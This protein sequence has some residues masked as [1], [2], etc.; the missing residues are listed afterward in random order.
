MPKNDKRD[1]LFI[2]HANPEDNNFAL[3]LTLRLAAEG[4]AV[5]CDLTE[6]LGGEDFWKKIENVLRDRAV[7]FLFVTSHSSTKKDGVL[8]ELAEAKEVAK[9]WTLKDFV[10]PLHIDNCKT[11]IEIKRINY[12]PFENSWSKGLAQLLK[13]LEKETVP[14]TDR[15]GPTLVSACVNV[16]TPRDTVT[17]IMD[18]FP[19]VRDRDISRTEIRNEAAEVIAEGNDP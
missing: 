9:E 19:I 10:I 15:F 17:Y 16:P 14:K 13:K 12:I 2:S 11:N 4:Y 5:W 8:Q 18:P 7:K 6:L 3:W 1:V